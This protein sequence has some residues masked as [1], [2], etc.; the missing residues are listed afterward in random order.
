M[1]KQIVA[2]KKSLAGFLALVLCFGQVQPAFALRNLQPGQQKSGLEELEENLKPRKEEAVQS[3]VGYQGVLKRF[4]L[5]KDNY[6]LMVARLVPNKGAH[7]LIEAF[8]RLNKKNLTKNKKLVIVGGSTFT[9][10]YV[11]KIKQIILAFARTR[12]IQL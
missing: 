8:N 6:V 11:A 12:L 1:I 3:Q 2:S 5:K 7:Y 10:K 4:G 9:D